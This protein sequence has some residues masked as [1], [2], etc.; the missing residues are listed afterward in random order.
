MGK[1][2]PNRKPD[3][4]PQSLSEGDSEDGDSD[5]QE[6]LEMVQV[7]LKSNFEIKSIILSRTWWLFLFAYL[8]YLYVVAQHYQNI[9]HFVL[10]KRTLVHA[11][12]TSHNWPTSL[13]LENEDF[14]FFFAFRLSLTS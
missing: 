13:E 1:K 12:K 14:S 3:S 6:I 7:A 11:K 10:L 4:T 9:E 8:V 5:L 2:N